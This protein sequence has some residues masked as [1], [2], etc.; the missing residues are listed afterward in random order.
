MSSTSEGSNGGTPTSKAI[1][2]SMS[3][4]TA[5]VTV[6]GTQQLT[7]TVANDSANKGV[8]WALSGMGCSGATC[9]T[10][11]AASSA[12]G[13]AITYTA[14]AGVPNPATVTLTATSVADATK[15]AATKITVTAAPL[16]S[17]AVT[18]ASASVQVATTQAFTA[19]LQNDSQNKGVNWTLSGLGCTGNIS[20]CG[21]L[22]ATSSASGVGITYTAPAR[23]PSPMRIKLTATSVADPSKSAAAAITVTAG[24]MPITVS[25]TPATASVQTGAA[26]TFTAAVANDAANKGVTW[27]VSGPGCSG[28]A[29]GTV[30]PWSSASGAPVTYTAPA[31]VPNPA[32]VTLTAT[33][34][35]DATKAASATLTVTPTPAI[36]VTLSPTSSSVA[37]TA[38]QAFTATVANDAANKGVMWTVS[39]AGCSGATCGTVAP[40]STASGAAVTYTAPASVPNPATVTLTATSVTDGTKSAS[41]AITI[42]S[43]GAVSVTITPSRGGLAVS[44]PLN[45]TATISNDVGSQGVTWTATAGTFSAQSATTATYV[46]AGTAGVITV[47]A[48]S[49]TDVTKSASATIGVT[50]LAGVT[51]YHNDLSRDGVNVQEYALTTSNVNSGTFGKLFSCSVDGAVYAQPLWV[52]GLTIN[53]AT[54]NVLFVATQHDSLYAFDADA[55]P[56]VKLWQ[57]SLIDA[58]HGGSSAETSVPS[59]I[60]NTV[61]IGQAA[62]DITPETGVTGTPVIDLS[63]KTL[64][65]VSKSVAASGP[66]FFQRLHAIELTSGAEKFSGPVSITG[67]NLTAAGSAEGGTT[68]TFNPATQLQRAGLALVNGVVYVCWASHEDKAPYYGWVAGYSA[69]DLSQVG[70]FN[71]TPNGGY[72]GIWMSGGAPTADSSNNLYVITGNGNLSGTGNFSAPLDYGDSFIKLS[73]SSGLAITDFFSPSDQSTLGGNDKDLG[74][75]GAALL[76][77]LPSSAP[78]QQLLVGGGKGATFAGELY[79]LD[80]NALGGYLQGPGSTDAVVQE[81]SFNHAIFA[82]GAFW[83]NTLYIAGVFGPVQA[84]ALNPSTATFGTTAT[85][86]SSTTYGFPGATPSVSSSGTSNGIVW[87]Q[88]NSQYC[89]PQSAGCGPTVLHAYDAA[90]LGTELWN[91]GSTAGNAVKF[92]VPTVANGKVYIATRGSDTG[93]GGTGEV[94]VYGLLPN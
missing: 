19:T 75:G 6:G 9:G 27:A 74:A 87:S 2:V 35:S 20:L 45:F 93:A 70:A 39:G 22:S 52:P 89:T 78:H 8:T 54:H 90:N 43:S 24:P 23:V 25:V 81:F 94:D 61:G 36:M 46:A 32:T 58:A 4:G 41:A 86:S 68:V 64:F 76:I 59:G 60:G 37:V 88:D 73:T 71:T 85:S 47:T 80:P 66:T 11:S 13:A 42:T 12:S 26:G 62:G 14:P 82:T 3:V 77:S 17:V 18:P 31:T 65:V 79:V 53:G 29:C 21:M 40:V 51:T 15:S 5:T 69:S 44:Q 72:G 83:Q 33:S 91:S 34:L 48:T 1:T 57:V 38:T 92:T 10:L 63:S 16:I 67:Q 49:K 28:T 55:N 30:S 50:D 84:F 56:C 7:A